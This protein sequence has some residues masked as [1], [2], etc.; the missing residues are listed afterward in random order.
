MHRKSNLGPGV[1]TT[2]LSVTF[3]L[4]LFPTIVERHGVGMSLFYTALG[5]GFIWFLYFCIGRLISRAVA[6][7]MR[8]KGERPAP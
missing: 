5:V 2:F 3:A 8:R 1:W 4:L 7:E 6:E